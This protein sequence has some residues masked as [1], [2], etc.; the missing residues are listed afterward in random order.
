M[1]VFL[2]NAKIKKVLLKKELKLRHAEYIK[3]CLVKRGSKTEYAKAIGISSSFLSQIEKG[4]SKTPRRIFNSVIAKTGNKVTLQD[5]LDESL[6]II[7]G[8]NHE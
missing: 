4:T 8:K 1:H 7:K 2:V 5:L 6:V 3:E